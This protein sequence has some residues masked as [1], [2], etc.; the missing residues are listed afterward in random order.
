MTIMP[1][2]SDG[3]LSSLRTSPSCHDSTELYCRWHVHGRLMRGR[4]RQRSGWD[5]NSRPLGH[6]SAALDYWATYSVI[7]VHRAMELSEVIDNRC[8]RFVNCKTT[9]ELMNSTCTC[10]C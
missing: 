4:V 2:R 3:Y 9:A 1:R 10:M 8:K 6:E 5:W 7:W